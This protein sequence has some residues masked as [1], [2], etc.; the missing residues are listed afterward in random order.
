MRIIGRLGDVDFDFIELR[1]FLLRVS[2]P[3]SLRVVWSRVDV[4]R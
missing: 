4:R 3:S 2:V 1:D